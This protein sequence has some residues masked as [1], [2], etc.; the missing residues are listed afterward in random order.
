MQRARE[1]HGRLTTDL[2]PGV[3]PGGAKGTR[4]PDPLLAKHGQDVQHRPRSGIECSHR[5]SEYSNSRRVGRRAWTAA[6][7]DGPSGRYPAASPMSAYSDR[8]YY[9]IVTCS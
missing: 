7:Y 6:E 9:L 8:R 2:R 4:T 5:L 3:S 1:G